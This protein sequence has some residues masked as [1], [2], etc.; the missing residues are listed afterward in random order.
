MEMIITWGWEFKIRVQ[1]S[2]VG[3]FSVFMADIF[4]VS[5]GGRKK[6]EISVGPLYS[7]GPNAIHESR[8]LMT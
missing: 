1:Y 3:P 6:L 7:W 2:Y 8:A 5:P 4:I